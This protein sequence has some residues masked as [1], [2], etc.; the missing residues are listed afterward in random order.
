LRCLGLDKHALS[1]LQAI[2]QFLKTLKHD[3]L[4][5]HIEQARHVP[6]VGRIDLFDAPPRILYP[7]H[8]QPPL[9]GHPVAICAPF[10]NT[11]LVPHGENAAKAASEVQDLWQQEP[12]EEDCLRPQLIQ[13]RHGAHGID[14][15]LAIVAADR[16]CYNLNGQPAARPTS[17]KKL[18]KQ[19]D[20]VNCMPGF[21]RRM[22]KD[23]KVARTTQKRNECKHTRIVTSARRPVVGI[24]S[25]FFVGRSSIGGLLLAAHAPIPQG[26]QSSVNQGHQPL[27]R[28]LDALA[29]NQ[30]SRW[31]PAAPHQD[32]CNFLSKT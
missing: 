13:R 3:G 17:R 4:P 12:S 24:S 8:S 31:L 6:P 14:D 32:P 10:K 5:A 18:S 30:I 9:V 23:G 28:R 2:C 20:T 11:L 25:A 19:I 29:R 21:H 15:K 26:S 7:S 27:E 16:G 1:Y 22:G